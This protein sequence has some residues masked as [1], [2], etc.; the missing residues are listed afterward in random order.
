MANAIIVTA[1]K[2]TRD[3]KNYR[4]IYLLGVPAKVYEANLGKKIRKTE[5]TLEWTCN[6]LRYFGHVLN[7]LLESLIWNDLIKYKIVFSKLKLWL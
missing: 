1:Y 4:E 2:N 5:R 6:R 3:S 7:H